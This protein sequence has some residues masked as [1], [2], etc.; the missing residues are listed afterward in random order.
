MDYENI[1][2]GCVKN[3][4]YFLVLVGSVTVISET[5]PNKLDSFNEN[6]L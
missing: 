4:D 3:T 6:S 5:S 1:K 2:L